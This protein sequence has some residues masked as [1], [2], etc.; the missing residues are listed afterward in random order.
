[1]S[2]AHDHRFQ[3]FGRLVS[4]LRGNAEGGMGYWWAVMKRGVH[5][6]YHQISE[7]H[8]G[9]YVSEFAFRLNEGNVK[10]RTLAR[11]DAMIAL[12]WNRRITYKELTA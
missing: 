2:V 12:A 3:R 10:T 1:M 11:L 5:G 6:V 4:F 9:R 7:K 8:L